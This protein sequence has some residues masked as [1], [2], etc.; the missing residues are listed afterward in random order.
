MRCAKAQNDTV[1]SQKLQPAC[2]LDSKMHQGKSQ[3][4]KKPLDKTLE[5]GIQ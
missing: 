4:A 5:T 3:R 1:A 2:W